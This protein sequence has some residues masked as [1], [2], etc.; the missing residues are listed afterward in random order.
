MATSAVG[1]RGLLHPDAKQEK[2]GRQH[3]RCTTPF[4]R[5]KQASP[6]VNCR[7]GARNPENK[8]MPKNRKQREQQ[9]HRA[10]QQQPTEG[11]EGRERSDDAGGPVPIHESGVVYRRDDD[12][13]SLCHCGSRCCTLESTNEEEVQRVPTMVR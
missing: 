13:R 6:F 4:L 3:Y 1:E 5:R 9:E 7:V 10:K 2:W 11:R 8:M 12:W